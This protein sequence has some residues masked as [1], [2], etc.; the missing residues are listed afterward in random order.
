MATFDPAPDD[1]SE[2]SIYDVA[3]A[4]GVS[5]STVSRVL[6]D[7]P[8]V[9]KKTRARVQRVINELGYIPYVQ[10]IQQNT[11][12]TNTIALLYPLQTQ[13]RL[14]MTDIELD[15]ML[16]VSTA[17]GEAN[18]ALNLMTRDIDE[19]ELLELYRSGQVR[20]VILMETSLDDW[21]VRLLRQN[22]Y[23]FVMIGRCAN[24]DGLSFIDIDLEAAVVEAFDHLIGLGHREIGF[25]AFPK[26]VYQREQTSAELM[27]SGYQRAIQ[28]YDLP[29]YMRHVDFGTQFAYEATCDL[30]R[31]APGLT[32]MVMAYGATVAGLTRALQEHGK[33]VPDNFSVVG[34]ASGKIASLTHPALSSSDFPFQS[35]GYQAAN[36]L[37]DNLSRSRPGVQQIIVPPQLTLRETT[38]PIP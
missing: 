23:P 34:V 31:E 35:V 11:S 21:R 1:P 7:K 4:A 36:M 26:G 13:S 38:G 20:G 33:S 16:G 10:T 37:I 14:E 27:L 22:G 32:A 15:F 18:Y 3:K 5:V 17:A 24:N 25:M 29:T 2:V 30:L 9:A 6:N 28:K 12:R 19:T 8:D